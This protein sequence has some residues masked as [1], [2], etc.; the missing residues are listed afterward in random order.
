[1]LGKRELPAYAHHSFWCVRNKW[2]ATANAWSPV[3]MVKCRDVRCKRIHINACFEHFC[4]DTHKCLFW[5]CLFFSFLRRER[6]K[7]ESANERV[8]VWVCIFSDKWVPLHDKRSW[9]SV[10]SKITVVTV[11]I[12]P[13]HSQ[14]DRASARLW[15]QDYWYVVPAVKRYSGTNLQSAFYSL[16]YLGLII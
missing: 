13:V 4:F 16:H 14:F 10:Q 12:F 1:M 7:K 8:F 2:T 5:V 15:G 3:Q 9:A 6:V 11:L